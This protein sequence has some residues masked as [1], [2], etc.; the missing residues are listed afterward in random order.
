MFPEDAKILLFVASWVN[1]I[2]SKGVSMFKEMLRV[3]RERHADIFTVVIGHLEDQSVLGGEFAGKETGWISDPHR[4]RLHYAAADVFVSPTMAENS[5]CTIAEAMACA[6][7]VVAFATGGV[8]E[9]VRDGRTGLLVE[10]G[11]VPALVE[12]VDAI[13]R[14]DAK[15]QAF[16]A[17]GAATVRREYTMDRFVERHLA[18]YE[19]TVAYHRL[20]TLR[21]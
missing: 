9:Q 5:S 7:T 4:M 16:G 10:R 11:N 3:L 2:P 1:S 12:S 19:E 14:D 18:I 8:P 15:C 17:E 20:G 6:T 21:D 13:L